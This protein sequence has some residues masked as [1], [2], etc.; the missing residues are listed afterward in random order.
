MVGVAQLEEH[1][2]VDLGVAGSKPVAHPFPL[3]ISFQ[4]VETFLLFCHDFKKAPVIAKIDSDSDFFLVLINESASISFSAWR[5][6][7]SCLSCDLRV[8]VDSGG[9]MQRTTLMTFECGP[10]RSHIQILY[11]DF[12][13]TIIQHQLSDI[14]FLKP[15]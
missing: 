10:A 11:S 3:L 1:K 9:I 7:N 12:L 15:A 13:N 4:R 2:I 6:F 8:A 5:L 14:G